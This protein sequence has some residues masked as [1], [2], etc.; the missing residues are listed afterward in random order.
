VTIVEGR[1]L[2]GNV[3]LRAEVVVIGSGAGGAAIA[4]WLA[5]A[6]VDVLIL[7]E[8]PSIPQSVYGRFR[9]TE[10]LRKMGREAG[11]SPVLSLGDTPIL[12][13]M[14]GRAVGGS[15]ILT[16]GVCF[17][18][19]EVIHQKWVKERNLPM[20]SAKD[21]EPAFE[22]V[23]QI[24]HVEEVPLSMRSRSTTKFIEGA[25]QLGIEMKS[26]RR[27][28]KGCNGCGRCNFGCPHGA[29]LSV[30]LTY[31]PMARAAGA[32]IY[33][34]CLVERIVSAG[35]K[36]R[37]VVGARLGPRNEH[38]RQERIGGFWVEAEVIVVAAGAIHSPQV[39][40]RSGF[41]SPAVGRHLTL[42]PG[43]RA[44]AAFE[45]K[46]E[47]WKG[48]LQ[49]AYSDHFEHEGITLTGLF[50]PPNVLAAALPGV[51]PS[52]A[53]RV[54]DIGHS[55]IFGGLVHDDAGGRVRK[56]FGREPLITY[57]MSKQNKASTL[58]C[59]QILGEAF[60]AAGAK[61]VYLPIFGSK[62]VRDRA[63]L[64]AAVPANLPARRIECITFHP[65]GSCRIAA[66]PK[67]GVVDPWGQTY[68]LPNVFLAD[69]SVV[70]SSIGVNSQLTVMA[71]ATRIGW[72]L[73]DRLRDR[74][75]SPTAQRVA[76]R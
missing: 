6:G 32:R 21:L 71:M 50:V 33:S 45:E 70:P 74:A 18:I 51:G 15:S 26:M 7:E 59:M 19:P 4:K 56:G 76:I 37:A 54:S 39:L 3:N 8:G 12:S 53:K 65:L 22:S 20:L 36:A 41:R 10:T 62:P 34:D 58:R 31:L 28:T 67:D 48:A 49:S 75:V 29:K 55:A 72:R 68:E 9:P 44:V 69:G 11:T 46:I 63:D 16:G 66:E 38:G 64:A 52:F 57:R 30:D 27:N 42:H 25:H 5:E 73:R 35:G 1:N 23:E 61:E 17:R 2:S 47:G 13:V 43:I 60:L 24:S 14:A 40:L